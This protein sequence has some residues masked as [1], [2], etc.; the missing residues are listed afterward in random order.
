MGMI[1]FVLGVIVGA[2]WGILAVLLVWE[3]ARKRNNKTKN[4]G[5]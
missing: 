2:V 1:K 5:L 4:K 3:E